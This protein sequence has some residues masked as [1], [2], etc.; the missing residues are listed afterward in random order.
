MVIE[1]KTRYTIAA[2]VARERTDWLSP[3]TSE[4]TIHQWSKQIFIFQFQI[5]NGRTNMCALT[6][7]INLESSFCLSWQRP[8]QKEM[9]QKTKKNMPATVSVG[10]T[11]PF[12]RFPLAIPREQFKPVALTVMHGCAKILFHRSK[13]NGCHAH[14]GKDTL[15]A[16][17][18]SRNKSCPYIEGNRFE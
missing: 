18:I 16:G 12:L 2:A 14:K 17:T 13:L 8:V 7:T 5:S 11:N 9:E 6:D 10:Q 1:L 4:P 3:A 15:F